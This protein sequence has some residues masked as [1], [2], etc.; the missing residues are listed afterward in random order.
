MVAGV[1][2]QRPSGG[3]VHAERGGGAGVGVGLQPNYNNELSPSV[4]ALF[5]YRPRIPLRINNLTV[6]IV[7]TTTEYRAAPVN[8]GYAPISEKQP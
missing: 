1:D 8:S 6:T 5:C 7:V 4:T 3:A 2:Q